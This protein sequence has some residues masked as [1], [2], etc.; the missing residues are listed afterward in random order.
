MA[1]WET[2]LTSNNHRVVDGYTGDIHTVMYPFL[3]LAGMYTR[4]QALTSIGALS[5]LGMSG[6]LGDGDDPSG[7]EGEG[8]EGEGSV[9]E[10][11]DENPF[12]PTVSPEPLPEDVPLLPGLSRTDEPP[13][14]TVEDHRAISDA[15]MEY[16]GEF[17]AFQYTETLQGTLYDSGA[18]VVDWEID[19]E[20]LNA[21]TTRRETTVTADAYLKEQTY[22]FTEWTQEPRNAQQALR[23]FVEYSEYFSVDAHVQRANA[24]YDPLG[25]KEGDSWDKTTRYTKYADAEAA[26][27]EELAKKRDPKF[28]LIGDIYEA[29]RVDGGVKLKTYRD[30]RGTEDESELADRHDFHYWVFDDAGYIRERRKMTVA[31]QDEDRLYTSASSQRWTPLDTTPEQLEPEWVEETREWEYPNDWYEG[32]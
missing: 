29:E 32:Q 27:Q 24:D 30:R 13:Y 12:E 21:Q 7:G 8:E 14:I 16:V 25:V 15:H 5:A 19:G 6:C 17:P 4:R 10:D 1:V 2:T 11:E 3:E 20:E 18:E 22:D 31:L 23:R 26:L 28:G 9:D